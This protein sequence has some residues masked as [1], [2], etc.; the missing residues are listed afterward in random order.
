MPKIREGDLYEDC[1]F[2][3]CLCYLAEPIVASGGW[4]KWLRRTVDVDL[5]G[6]SLLDGSRL[7]CSARHCAPKR[8]TLAEV[9]SMRGLWEQ[10]Q[11]PGPPQ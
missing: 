10:R 11:K 5:S 8:L 6:I 2:H 9:V 1:A 7:S 4:R 3:P